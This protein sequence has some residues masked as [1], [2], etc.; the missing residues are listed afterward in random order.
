M[1]KVLSSMR[2]DMNE[3]WAWISSHNYAPRSIIKI[4]NK[5]NGSKVY[6]ESLEIDGNFI[7]EYN[8]KNSQRIK[9]N[10][11]E[12]TIILNGWHRKRLGG[13]ETN[14]FH[15]LEVSDANNLWGKLCAGADH[16]QTVVR[17]TTWLGV[18]SAG[19]GLIGVG[20][21]LISVEFNFIGMVILFCGL[22]VGMI[23]GFLAK[24]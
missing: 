1:Y 10:K 19:L 15:N 24:K 14:K 20:L 12:K 9:I 13:I 23:G 3:G 22:V 21:G 17:I 18:I 7:T 16:P 4:K 11:A 6:C 5:S 2:A 8:D